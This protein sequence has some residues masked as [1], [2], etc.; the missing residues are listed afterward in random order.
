MVALK[1]TLIV[2]LCGYLSGVLLLYGV[3]RSL[4]YFPE[5][6]RT[7]PAAVGLTAAE[8]VI[9]DTADGE[10]VVVWHIPPR[11]DQPV[12]LYL[13]GNGGALSH[14][15]ERFRVLTA[16]GIGLV[17]VDYRGYGGSSGHPTEAGLLIDAETAYAFAVARYPVER[18][19]VWGESLGTG[20]AVPLAAERPVGGIILEAP[21]TSTADLAARQYPFVPVRWLMKDQFRSDLEIDKVT[22]PLLIMHGA[23]DPIVPIA[24]GERLFALAH[25]PKRFLR[26]GEGE[27]ENLDHFGALV[28]VK[29]FLAEQLEGVRQ[30][31]RPR[32][33]GG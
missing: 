33:G 18:I 17:G 15:A 2:L 28:A 21:F 29:A 5:T 27:H 3:Q 24:Y 26:F 20:V 25:E 7:P 22:A 16:D 9:R 31:T 23:R 14:R 1:W 11:G 32:Q 4:M 10:H 12:V 6:A 13:H 30:K 8:E 19:A